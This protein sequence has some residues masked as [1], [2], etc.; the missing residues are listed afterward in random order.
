MVLRHFVYRHRDRPNK[1]LDPT[2]DRRI[3]YLSMAKPYSAKRSAFSSAVAQLKL[4][5]HC[6]CCASHYPLRY[7]CWV[8][9][10]APQQSRNSRFTLPMSRRPPLRTEATSLCPSDPKK[11]RSSH[12]CQR[13]LLRSEFISSFRTTACRGCSLGSTRWHLDS[14]TDSM[15]C[16]FVRPALQS[17]MEHKSNQSIEST[18]DR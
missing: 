18:G 10:P 5:R 16:I 14:R 6:A 7:C 12:S 9:V 17:E 1:P 8:L 4:V 13:T 2:A 3:N 11:Q 15:R